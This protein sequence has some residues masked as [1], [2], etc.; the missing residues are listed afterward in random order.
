MQNNK[1]QKKPAGDFVAETQ[2]TTQTG[3]LYDLAEFRRR[4][5]QKLRAQMR[6]NYRRLKKIE[7]KAG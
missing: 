7:R 4:R 2:V 3:T 5:N 1:A 6:E